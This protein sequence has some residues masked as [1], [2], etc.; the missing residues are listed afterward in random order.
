M[1]IVCYCVP[2]YPHGKRILFI[3]R[4]ARGTGE[5]SVREQTSGIS[6]F[7]KRIMGMYTSGKVRTWGA[8]LNKEER[9]NGRHS[10]RGKTINSYKGR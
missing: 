5:C 9:W 4:A 1:P 8:I 2:A 7:V 10:G 3:R 6:E